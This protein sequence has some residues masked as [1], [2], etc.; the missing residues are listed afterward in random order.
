MVAKDRTRQGR[1]K[2]ILLSKRANIFYIE[3]ARIVQK[4]ER[5]L[6]LTDTGEQ[7]ER[8]YNLPE[9]NTMFLLLGKGTS[10][11]DAAMRRLSESNVLV[12]FCGSGGSPQF[13]AAS[14]VFL[15]TDSEYRPTRYMQDWAS[16]WFCEDRRL[17]KA[18]Q[19]LKYRVDFVQ[20]SWSNHRFLR[21]RKILAPQTAITKF[22]IGIDQA[23][24]VQSL[25]IAEAQWARELYR[26][27]AIRYS[28]EGFSRKEGENARSTSAE[29]IN[30]NLDH[31]NYIAY[32]YSAMLLNALGISFSF[33]LLHGKTRRGALVFDIADPIKD[34]FVMPLA[35]DSGSR[36][37]EAENAFRAQLIEFV[38]ESPIID[39]IFTFVE[40]LSGSR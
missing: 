39:E 11:T 32:G 27:L 10:I 22:Q 21:E 15:P 25:L 36:E 31:G 8:Y 16:W 6:F 28:I 30:S 13:G 26:W 1:P 38:C 4:D 23:R 33:P 29:R 24:D 3:H 7:I 35:F 12:G 17:D 2:Q 5:V 37:K 40:N 19:L 14:P 20:K 18:K 9:R 34:A